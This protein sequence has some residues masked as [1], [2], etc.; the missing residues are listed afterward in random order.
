MQVG[1]WVPRPQAA[2][3][4][5]FVRDLRCLIARSLETNEGMAGLGTGGLVPP[6]LFFFSTRKLA[7]IFPY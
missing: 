6:L 5:S 4:G 2:V 7:C 1:V 3:E